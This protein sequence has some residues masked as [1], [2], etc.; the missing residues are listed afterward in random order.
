M[1]ELGLLQYA[2]DFRSAAV[3][4]S[5]VLLAHVAGDA[6]AVPI[7]SCTRVGDEA[8]EQECRRMRQWMGVGSLIGIGLLTIA[9]CAIAAGTVLGEPLVIL[10]GV[11]MCFIVLGQTL[12]HIW[13]RTV[14]T[15]RIVAARGIELTPDNRCVTIENA[16]TYSK[17]KFIPEDMAILW[18]DVPGHCVRLEGMGHRYIIYAADV[19]NLSVR[20]GPAQSSTSITY[21]MGT[22]QLAL[23]LA[24]NQ[25]N[26][27]EMF[28]Q[29]VGLA[30]RLHRSLIAALTAP[31]EEIVDAIP[32]G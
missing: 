15:R 14:R 9:L 1:T 3:E 11:G 7:S 4:A 17:M 12:Y 27:L 24:E 16:L 20:R 28:L 10:G 26:L 32:E 22:A 8:S 13:R 30:P 6:D 29:T 25:G 23:T 18:V 5:G 19:T 31:A 2:G 21:R